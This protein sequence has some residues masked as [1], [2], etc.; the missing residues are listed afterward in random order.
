M[1]ASIF[2]SVVKSE[3][4]F[5]PVKLKPLLKMSITRLRLVGGK[6]KNGVCKERR[7]LADL[8]KQGNVAGCRVRVEQVMREESAL[9]GFE[10]LGMLTDLV[11]SRLPSLANSPQGVCPPEMKEAITSLIWAAPYVGTHVPEFVG[12]RQQIAAKF[13]P[14]FVSNAAKN[15][16]LSVHEQLRASFDGTPPSEERCV[17]YMESIVEEFRIAIDPAV[18]RGSGLGSRKENGEDGA[19]SDDEEGSGA[20]FSVAGV[21]I[22]ELTVPRD[23]ME[24]KLLALKRAWS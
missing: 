7:E 15:L 10:I 24:A 21:W 22:P 17:R 5:D 9:N 18:L 1:F 3:P 11:S 4:K 8:L 16:E 13:G 23:D 20:G 6:R 19:D 12:I 2:G 14:E